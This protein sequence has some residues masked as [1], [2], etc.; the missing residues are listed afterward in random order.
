MSPWRNDTSD[1]NLFIE[2]RRGGPD[3]ND[4]V[5][6]IWTIVRA[7]D[8]HA[9]LT[10]TVFLQKVTREGRF[11]FVRRNKAGEGAGNPI[12]S[13]GSASCFSWRPILCSSSARGTNEGRVVFILEGES[14][15]G[16]PGSEWLAK[17]CGV[18]GIEWV[19]YN[20][21]TR[22]HRPAI[23][24]INTQRAIGYTDAKRNS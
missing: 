1:G 20:N 2:A 10:E 3:D 17:K 16:S 24:W 13:A 11:L 8:I 7:R 15:E 12:V 14:R 5:H 9:T 4:D 23:R 22:R 19:K 21:G 6:L 18:P